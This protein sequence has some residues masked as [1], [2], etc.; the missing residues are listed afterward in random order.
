MK[1]VRT[2]ALLLL[3]T[4]LVARGSNAQTPARDPSTRL[5]E[6]LPADVAERVLA[7]IADARA[8]QLPAEALENRALK[9]AAKGVD[10]KAVERSVNEQA[11]RMESARSAL[12]SGRGSKPAG[13]EIEAGAE[14]LRKGVDGA[15]V[16][17]FAKS[18]PHDRPLAV[19][20]FV[21]GSL[22][23]RGLT[24]GQALQRVL[25]GL[26][27]RASDADLESMPGQLPAQANAGQ[28]NRPAETGQAFGQSHKP[29]TTGRPAPA[30]PPAGL[31]A[32]GGKKSNPGQTH[33]PPP[34]N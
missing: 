5:R 9:F 12:V 30:G 17:Q 19:A 28:A 14:V 25:D 16:A 11:Q 27:A 7:R 2:F 33:R 1:N 4:V 3:A 18:A 29:T 22:T 32:N 6:V 8:R 26:N 15:A 20:L 13:D 31:P 23:D 24:P 10:P 34:N 21:V